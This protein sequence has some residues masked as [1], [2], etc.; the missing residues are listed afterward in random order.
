MRRDGS[1]IEDFILGEVAL[2]KKKNF[3]QGERN[4]ISFFVGLIFIFIFYGE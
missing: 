1:E 4:N 3:Q 2:I